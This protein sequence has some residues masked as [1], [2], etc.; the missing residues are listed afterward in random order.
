M[1]RFNG[2][3][4]VCSERRYRQVGAWPLGGAPGCQW[5]GGGAHLSR[6]S[7]P[8]RPSLLLP[9]PCRLISIWG[10]DRGRSWP[11]GPPFTHGPSLGADQ[12]QLCSILA[13][14][15]VLSLGRLSS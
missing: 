11:Q 3:C 8:T 5:R 13:T 4:K 10:E 7:L 2:L 14:D 1:N 6:T 9:A 12:A 15:M